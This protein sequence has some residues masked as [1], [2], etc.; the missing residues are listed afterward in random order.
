MSKTDFKGAHKL[1]NLE[2]IPHLF[3][4]IFPTQSLNFKDRNDPHKN[5]KA[6]YSTIMN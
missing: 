3:T 4:R 5:I 1:E 6:S 2:M